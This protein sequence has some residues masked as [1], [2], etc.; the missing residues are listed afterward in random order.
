MPVDAGPPRT[1]GNQQ[2]MNE[3][4]TNVGERAAVFKQSRTVEQK[5]KTDHDQL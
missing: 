2:V 4:E 3:T 5:R 1:S